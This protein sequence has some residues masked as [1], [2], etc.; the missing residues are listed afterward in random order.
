M[1]IRTAG[2][3][4]QMRTI[5][6]LVLICLAGVAHAQG[7]ERPCVLP[8]GSFSL[9]SSDPQIAFKRFGA[10]IGPLRSAG[11]FVLVNLTGK[12]ITR[13]LIVAEFLDEKD[14]A[15]ISIPFYA[16]TNQELLKD[17]SPFHLLSRGWIDIAVGAGQSIVLSG[18][19]YEVTT[20]CPVKAQVSLVEIS[21]SDGT[22]LQHQ[23]GHPEVEPSIEQARP[24]DL[25]T[26]PGQKPFQG[27]FKV[28]FAP[29]G[30]ISEIS[31][32]Q[33]DEIRNWFRSQL[34]KWCFVPKFRDGRPVSSEL[35]L[36]FR[37]NGE[38]LLH[39]ISADLPGPLIVIDVK[40]TEEGQYV[41][42]GG[43]LTEVLPT[44]QG[45]SASPCWGLSCA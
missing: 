19:T 45:T 4:I 14:Q 26:F 40:D 11:H 6:M 37:L 25:A 27:D 42:A 5:T 30:Q 32:S 31:S 38:A 13:I 21:F 20:R 33:S 34:S 16:A 3:E 23:L 29:D 18:F 9:V 22:K 44:D 12:P 36:V 43:G 2:T 15:M 41:I 39:A 7:T 28:T 17:P 24:L 10:E 8:N 1:D 35:T